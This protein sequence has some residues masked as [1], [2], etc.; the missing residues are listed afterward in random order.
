VIAGPT[1]SSYLTSSS[2]DCNFR[3]FLRQNLLNCLSNAPGCD[4]TLTGAHQSQPDR[5][6]LPAELA[7]NQGAQ[8]RPKRTFTIGS[9]VRNHPCATPCLPHI[10]KISENS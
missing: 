4:E 2:V 7:A 8:R 10:S 6:I 3:N 1:A 5:E 9:R